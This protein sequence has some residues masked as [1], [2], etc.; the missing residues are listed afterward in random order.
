M[1]WPYCERSMAWPHRYIPPH[2]TQSIV[3]SSPNYL[4]TNS[5]DR[6]PAF[7][8]RLGGGGGFV[9][10]PFLPRAP[11]P[12]P[13]FLSLPPEWPPHPPPN[14][15]PFPWF[16]PSEFLVLFPLLLSQCPL[17]ELRSLPP[18]NFLFLDGSMTSLPTLMYHINASLLCPC[19]GTCERVQ[20]LMQS[21]FERKRKQISLPSVAKGIRRL[22]ERITAVISP[23]PS[24]IC[25][26]G[27]NPRLNTASITPPLPFGLDTIMCPEGF[28]AS[29]LILCWP[30]HPYWR[31]SQPL[32]SLYLFLNPPKL[33]EG[34]WLHILYGC[35]VTGM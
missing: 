23:S 12:P 25:S 28:P 8:A 5:S 33:C 18:L 2:P 17:W 15:A 13:L 32:P 4:L 6:C 19:T 24:I 20:D 10:L 30:I 14:L 21:P 3:P 29:L 31:R 7:S 16:C 1:S 9:L 22:S 34:P 26:C 27:S 11:P 35:H